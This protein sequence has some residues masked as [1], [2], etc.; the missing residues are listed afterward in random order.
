M[1][2]HKL[3]Q[4]QARHQQVNNQPIPPELDYVI[5]LKHQQ[6]SL[7]IVEPSNRRR[8]KLFHIAFE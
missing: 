3:A 7:Q 6:Q 5:F 2:Y 8:T 1:W 4:H